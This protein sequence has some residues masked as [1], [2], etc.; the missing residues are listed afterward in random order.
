MYY[1]PDW[2]SLTNYFK[3]GVCINQKI[4]KNIKE[5]G[6][7]FGGLGKKKYLKY[8]GSALVKQGLESLIFGYAPFLELVQIKIVW[9]I[10]Q[11]LALF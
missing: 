8:F 1:I 6:Y 11:M 2:Y 7:Y 9:D 10:K 3:G 5:G 4:L